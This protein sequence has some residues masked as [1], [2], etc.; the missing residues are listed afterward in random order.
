MRFDYERIRSMCWSRRK[1]QLQLE[2]LDRIEREMGDRPGTSAYLHRRWRESLSSYDRTTFEFDEE[3][4][5]A[6]A[7]SIRHEVAAEEE[8]YR[9]RNVLRFPERR[10]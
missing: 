3:E 10:G 8:R 5:K 7:E 1:A 2:L 9:M 6:V 4:A